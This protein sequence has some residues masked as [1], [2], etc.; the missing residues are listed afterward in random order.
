MKHRAATLLLVPFLLLAKDNKDKKAYNEISAD[1]VTLS[2]KAYNDPAAIKQ[3]LGNDLGG[4]YVVI[5]MTVTPKGD[6]PLNVQLND[7][8]IFCEGDGDRTQPQTPAEITASDS[9][10]LKRGESGIGSFGEQTG[11]TWSGVGFGG[12]SSKKKKDDTPDSATMK[13]GTKDEGL[14][15]LLEEKA[16]PEKETTEPVSGLLYF[17]IE[18]KKLKNLVLF[19]STPNGKLRLYFK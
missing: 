18:K 14:K 4:H 8:Q 19:Y 9:L 15:D 16:L 17:P 11:T 6:K 3:L 7:F 12:R 1:T 2:G 5:Q 13:K 10:V